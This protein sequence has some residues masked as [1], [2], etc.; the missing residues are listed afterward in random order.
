MTEGTEQKVAST[1]GFWA[2]L[3]DHPWFIRIAGLFSVIAL[4]L[5]FWFYYASIQK[6]ELSYAINPVRT[7]IVRPGQ[8]SSMQVS[9]NGNIISNDL[10]SVQIAIWNAGRKAIHESEILAPIV[11]RPVPSTAIYEARSSK[12][13]RSETVM[14]IHQELTNAIPIKWKILEQ[15]D[16]CVLT[17]FYAGGDNID[18]V[19]DGTIEDQGKVKRVKTGQDNWISSLILFTIV[20]TTTIGGIFLA[21]ILAK[22]RKSK[23]IKLFMGLT[24]LAVVITLSHYLPKWLY[25]HTPFGF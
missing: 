15:N 13:A 1:K 20:G 4:P 23:K 21:E 8:F 12:Q 5:S 11:I 24:L 18:F 14:N 16:G 25:A 3:M 6:P 22:R 7:T 19:V 2:W 9:I 10:S 17:L